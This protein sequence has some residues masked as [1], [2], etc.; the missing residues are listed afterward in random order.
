[1]KTTRLRVTLAEVSPTVRRVIDVPAAITLDELHDVLQVALGWTDSHLHQ[2]RTSAAVYSIASDDWDDEGE[3][4]ERGVRLSAL[5]PRF[6]YLYDFGDG[7][8]HDV[9]VLGSGG[10]VA[11]CVDGE[12]AC[13]PEDCGGPPGYAELLTAVTDP[14]HPERQAMREWAGERLRPFDQ[15]TAD[16]RVRD[17]V[18]SVPESVRLLLGLLADGAKLTPGG[19]LPR[20]VVRAVQQ[21][22]PDWYPLGRPASIEEDLLPLAAL[23]D[24]LRHVGLLRLAGGVLRPT[25]AA[26]DEVETVRRLRT[27]FPPREFHTLVAERAMALV[28]ARGPLKVPDLAAEVFAMLG[29][30]WRRG[31]D[32]I[33][34]TDVQHDLYRLA[35][36]LAA[37]DMLAA[38]SPAWTAGPSARS[39]L[40][41]VALLAD[42]V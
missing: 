20:V 8:T 6:T 16:R 35:H 28:A 14:R 10:D 21:R 36:Q 27:W 29:Q 39:L 5:P 32:P 11:G 7:W 37:V 12:G 19:R 42:L 34:V 40:P 15:Q 31:N 4:D 38:I 25:K 30:G 18:G 26:G 33:T 2:Y 1:M 13:P 23:H 3:T 17:A 41:G 9:Q 24:V 22:R